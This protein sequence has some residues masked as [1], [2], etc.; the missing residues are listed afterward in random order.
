MKRE[1]EKNETM[2]LISITEFKDSGMLWL[3][4]GLLQTYGMSI[5]WD[6]EADELKPAIVRYRGFS[7]EANSKGY[8]KLTAYMIEN[9]EQLAEDFD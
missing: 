5:V 1:F 6:K 3:I 8:K 7:E 4:N 9:A 2:Q